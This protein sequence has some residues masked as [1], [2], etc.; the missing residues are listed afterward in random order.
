VS[1][2]WIGGD[3]AGL[4]AIGTTTAPARGLI[5]DVVRALDA[6]VDSLAADAGWSGEAADAFRKAW[7]ENAIQAGGLAEVVVQVGT[8]LGGLGDILQKIE[9][10][11]YDAANQAAGQ[12]AQIGDRGVPAT[13]VITGDPAAPA[14]ATARQAQS[15]YASTYAIAMHTA[16]GYRIQA[17]DALTT[18]AEQVAPGQGPK[19]DQALTVADY[20]RGL[21][22]IPNEGNAAARA[23]LPGRIADAQSELRDARKDLRAAKDLYD[24]KGL[25]L[26][27]T[28]P[29]ALAHSAA[30]QDIAG[31]RDGLRGAESGAGELPL[32]RALNTKLGDVVG[33][34]PD[35]GKT[36][37]TGLDFLR[38]IP[39]VDVAASGAIAEIQARDDEQKGWSGTEARAKDYGA[40]AIGVAGGVTAVALMPEE[41]VAAAAAV[42]G[43]AVVGVGDIAYQAFHE[44]W[45]EDIHNDGVVGGL[46]DGSGHVLSNVGGDLNDMRK[47]IQNA[48]SSVWH[49]VFG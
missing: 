36:L 15:D 34:L 42:G 3:L 26:P 41:A 37:P 49:G 45:S 22:A 38:D 12:G 47:G 11:L 13:L 20:I 30:V 19:L 2:S 8:T 39:V 27:S 1:E 21:Y 18:L 43:L 40:A 28:S 6:K 23:A 32:S 10:D 44:H 4:Q 9:S 46:L 5:D 35:L 29:A 31:L 14:A 33:L 7:A 24:A 25:H 48:A 16:Q 17:A